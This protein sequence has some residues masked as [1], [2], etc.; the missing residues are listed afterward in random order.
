MCV[1]IKKKSGPRGETVCSG[2]CCNVQLGPW[3]EY[4]ETGEVKRIVCF[5]GVTLHSRQYAE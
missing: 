1:D 3:H 2:G 5:G 4:K